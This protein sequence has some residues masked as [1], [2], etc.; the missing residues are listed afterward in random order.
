MMEDEVWETLKSVGLDKS[1]G[2]NG[3]PYEVYL[4]LLHMFVP[5]LTTIYNNW[6][7]QGSIP[8]RFTRSIV[9]L[10]HKNKNGGNGISNFH[11]LTMLNTDLK[12]LVKIL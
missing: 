8:R 4:R 9:K 6:M 7:R 11:S 3:L 5:L 10:L 12:I 1:P 2:I